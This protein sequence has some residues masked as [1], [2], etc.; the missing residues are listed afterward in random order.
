MTHG[1]PGPERF[2]HCG[3]EKRCP[4]TVCLV[5][6]QRTQYEWWGVHSHKTE[7]FQKWRGRKIKLRWRE[8]CLEVL[9]APFSCGLVPGTIT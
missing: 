2:Q 7:F 8:G 4:S 5:G 3:V 6:E 9:Q 1:L